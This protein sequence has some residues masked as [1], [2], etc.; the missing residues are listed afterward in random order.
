MRTSEYSYLGY[1]IRIY[2]LIFLCINFLHTVQLK[3]NFKHAGYAHAYYFVLAR[4]FSYPLK[5]VQVEISVTVFAT[6][7][8][9]RFFY[10]LR[11]KSAGLHA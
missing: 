6:G 1:H 2:A 8:T 5:R 11:V 3:G 9:R 7:I 10:P 4:M